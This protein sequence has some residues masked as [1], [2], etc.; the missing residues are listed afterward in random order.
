L[1]LFIG[2]SSQLAHF[3]PKDN[4]TF[5]SSREIDLE[6]LRETQWENVYIAFADGRTYLGES[7]GVDFDKTNVK[8]TLSVIDTLLPASKKIFYFS[9]TE[10]FNLHNGPLNLRERYDS[11]EPFLYDARSRY[12]AS[13]ATIADELFL[14]DR[15]EK[16][17]ILYP[18]SFNSPYRKD[19]NFLFSKIFDSI[20]NKKQIQVGNIDQYRDLVHPKFVVRESL[21][22]TSH[23][24]IGSGRLTY[25]RDFIDSLYRRFG[26]DYSDY[27]DEVSEQGSKVKRNIFYLDSKNCRYSFGELLDDTVCDLNDIFRRE[28]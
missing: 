11:E 25:V 22:A 27:I 15:Y 13:K 20:I 21:N 7:K 18:F 14:K 26:M 6:K 1:N 4:T 5:V 28:E 12:I 23:K 2:K 17:V 10:L 19:P 9:T 24:I 8:Y 3:W 16:V